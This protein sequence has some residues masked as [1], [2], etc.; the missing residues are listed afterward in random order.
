MS[1]T[2]TKGGQTAD[3]EH[4]K[5]F[6]IFPSDS[7]DITISGAKLHCNKSGNYALQLEGDTTP[8]IFALVAGKTYRFRVKRVWRTNTDTTTAQITD[9]DFAAVADTPV[10]LNHPQLDPAVNPVVTSLDAVTTYTEG[11]DYNI[12]YAAGTITVLSTGSMVD[13]THYLVDYTYMTGNDLFGLSSIE[14]AGTN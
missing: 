1:R 9:E 10:Q 6:Q 12:D 2:Q 7:V 11:V 14:V 5:S 8:R 4:N 3:I 13:G